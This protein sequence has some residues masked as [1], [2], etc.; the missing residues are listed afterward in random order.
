MALRTLSALKAYFY[1]H[2]YPTWQQFHD[3]LDSFRHKS[4]KIAI[5]EIEDLTTQLNDKVSQSVMT[6][7][8]KLRQQNDVLIKEELDLKADSADV[9]TKSEVDNKVASVYTSRGSVANM[10]ALPAENNKVGDVYNLL[11]T[12]M[13][14][15]Y[16][17][18]SPDPWDPLGS[19]VP[20]ATNANDGL[21]SKETFVE[22]SNL[23][24]TVQKADAAFN[25]L[26]F[27]RNATFG[28]LPL[29]ESFGNSLNSSNVF[30]VNSNLWMMMLGN[31]SK[32]TAISGTKST[33]RVTPTDAS[34]TASIDKFHFGMWLFI[35]NTN[36]LKPDFNHDLNVFPGVENVQIDAM[37]YYSLT[38]QTPI[39]LEIYAG[40]TEKDDLELVYS[41]TGPVQ[42]EII[43][44]GLKIDITTKRF[45]GV[46]VIPQSNLQVNAVTPRV[47][48]IRPI[49]PVSNSYLF[50]S[51]CESLTLADDEHDGLMSIEHF[52]KVEAIP[53]VDLGGQ[54]PRKSIKM[55][56]LLSSYSSS[57]YD[58][59]PWQS[60][61]S[62]DTATGVF[63]KA[64]H[65][66]VANTAIELRQNGG[67]LPTGFLHY[68]DATHKE[69]G[70]YYTIQVLDANTFTLSNPFTN[71]VVKPTDV[72]SGAY[73]MRPALNK[74]SIPLPSIAVCTSLF[75]LIEF[76]LG[77][78]YIDV[79]ALGLTFNGDTAISNYLCRYKRGYMML[80]DIAMNSNCKGVIEIGITHLENGYY[81]VKANLS[82]YGSGGDDYYTD[83]TT[84]SFPIIGKW[85]ND[86]ALQ[87]VEFGD[88]QNN[89]RWLRSLSA[90]V[91]QQ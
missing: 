24:K 43:I 35:P 11:D 46:R 53:A 15:A 90:S 59:S 50:G 91:Y 78:D 20:L 45:I 29:V 58:L 13:N 33:F 38:N 27:V 54:F 8:T 10:A 40:S 37:F 26:Q 19:T 7:E 82:G 32:L 61:F 34:A 41:Y 30:S 73:Q 17:G 87:S 47:F 83:L 74:I 60:G 6:Q 16:T 76:T 79:P 80:P 42:N 64:N 12:G 84:T 39:G 22:I 63:T 85:L 2:A 88:F 1:E 21:M 81:F 86:A 51:V 9:Y 23:P 72:G 18:N 4:D 89:T 28:L 55:G 68:L 66:F 5:S 49:V 44:S 67:M 52:A 25:S 48:S 3:V 71:A 31:S 70:M 75:I 56:D 77:T 36:S 65:G 69:F 62:V 14:V 57:D